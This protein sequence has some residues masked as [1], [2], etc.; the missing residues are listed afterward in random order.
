MQYIL[1]IIIA[2][3]VLIFGLA[4]LNE[5]QATKIKA[6]ARAQT[7][8]IQ[9]NA[10]AQTQII[11]ANAQASAT[12]TQ[13]NAMMMLAALPVILAIGG[14]VGLSLAGA[15][16][17]IVA[18]RWQPRRVVEQRIVYQIGPG[19]PRRKLWQALSDTR[20]IEPVRGRYEITK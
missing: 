10:Q 5:S 6:E 7:Q 20:Q 4:W 2:A 9:A 18:I 13:A 11:Q 15:A 19:M 1:A 8:I 3:A 16:L 14:A 17:L 12:M